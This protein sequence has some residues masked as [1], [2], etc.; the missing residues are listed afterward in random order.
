VIEAAK[1]GEREVEFRFDQKGN[2]ELPQIMG[3]LPV[4]PHWWEGTDAKGNKRD[5]T[6]PTLEPPL[7]S[8]AYKIDL[9]ARLRRSSGRAYLTIGRRTSRSISAATISTAVYLHP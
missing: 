2:R 1:A 7:G 8:S 9:Q 3:D 4:L 5:V 6:K